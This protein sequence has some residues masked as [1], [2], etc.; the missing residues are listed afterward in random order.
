MTVN[1]GKILLILCLPYILYAKVNLKAP[2]SF[3]KGEQVVFSITG[4]G[5]K[6]E[7]PDIKN[8]DGFLLQ[9]AGTSNQTTI[10]NGVRNQSLTKNYVFIPTKDITIPSFEIKINGEIER[11]K[12][13]TIKMNQVKKTTSKYY[14]LTISIDKRNTYVGEE[15]K[16]TLKFKYRKDLQI[17]SLDFAKPQFEN[18]WVKELQS[19]ARQNTKGQFVEQELNY[20]LFPQKSGKISI[21]PL[22]IGIVVADDRYNRNGYGFFGT[23]TTKTIP[24]YSNKLDLDIKALPDDINVIGDFDISSTVDKTKINSGEAV[25]YKVIIK[26]RGNIDDVDEITLDIPNATIYDNPLKK[27]VDIKNNEYGGI[28]TK[29]YSIVAQNDF[30]IPSISLKYFDKKS[31]T[32]KTA[33]TKIYDIKVK[34]LV[35]KETKLQVLERPESKNIVKEKIVT[36][37]VETSD[38]EK[39]IYFLLGMLVSAVLISLSL[40]LFKNKN[41][42]KVETPLI[43]LVKK[44]NSSQELLKLLVVYINIDE[45][46]D[47]IIYNLESN[48]SNNNF[49]KLKKEV[50][51]IL[52]D[53]SLEIKF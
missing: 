8:I 49:K 25:A 28:Y 11:T 6:I 1:L 47:N 31:L 48:D 43:K 50:L 7:F 51:S 32:V 17:V 45:Q 42:D 53:R 52:K 14:D 30:T 15:I 3:Y 33:K 27:E 10:I 19:D 9:S 23:S 38:K 4:T 24:V 21:D 29:T 16:F 18:F 26:G 22:K 41:R 39:I 12:P 5:G 37:I 20:L 13:K 2:D 40:L 44:S 46:L 36:K 34:S 35:K